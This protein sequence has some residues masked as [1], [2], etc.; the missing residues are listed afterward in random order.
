MLLQNAPAA[1][2]RIVFA[3][4]GRGVRQVDGFADGVGDVHQALEEPGPHPT[5]FR[6]IIDLELEVRDRGLLGRGQV[7]PPVPQA[8][9]DEIAGFAGAAKSQMEPSAVLLHQ[10]ER[11]VLFRSAHVVVGGPVV[12]TGFPAACVIPDLHRGLAVD[13]QA[14]DRPVRVGIPLRQGLAIP[15]GEV[16][17]DGIGFREFFWGLALIALRRR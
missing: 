11:D 12:A 1:F 13:A 4:I 5:A 9:H 15:F 2:D 3:V 17:E 14:L 6:A 16:G 8:V 10:P 7:V